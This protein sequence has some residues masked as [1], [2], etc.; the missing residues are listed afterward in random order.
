VVAL[1]T[2][3]MLQLLLI[4]QPGSTS[5]WVAPDIDPGRKAPIVSFGEITCM[6]YGLQ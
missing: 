4:P 2:T 5:A 1:G 6:W 3:I